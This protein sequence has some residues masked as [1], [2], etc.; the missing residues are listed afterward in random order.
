MDNGL[1]AIT[2]EQRIDL[3]SPLTLRTAFLFPLQNAAARHEVL[4]GALWLLLPVVGWLLNMGHRIEMVHQMQHGHEAWPAW[5]RPGRLLRS[6]IITFAGMVYYYIPAMLC[7]WL[8]V[9]TASIAAWAG[10]A[11]FWL[12]ATLAIPG[13]MTH[14]CRHFKMREIFNPVRALS[15]VLQAGA[16]YWRAWLIAVSALAISFLGLLAL[17]I[18]FFVTS[19]WFWQVAGYSFANA[20]TRRHSLASDLSTTSPLSHGAIY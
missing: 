20:M 7:L 9:R 5:R 12:A 15:R 1:P 13:Y 14:Y 8:A 6:G 16:L 18:G 17:G 19:V 4:I 11:V 10:A 2:S 3:G